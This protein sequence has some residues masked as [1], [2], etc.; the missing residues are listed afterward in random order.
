MGMGMVSPIATDIPT[1]PILI[2]AS[3]RPKLSQ[4]L[5]LM[6]NTLPPTVLDTPPLLLTPTTDMA[7]PPPMDMVSVTLDT[8]DLDTESV[9]PKLSQRLMLS[10]CPHTTLDT[11]LLLT[12]TMDI[13]TPPPMAMVTVTLDTPDLDMESVK[14]RLSQ[15]LMLN[16]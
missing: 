14:L 1:A 3:V 8:P 4:R 5:M 11:P 10:T 6:L 16:T 7:F 13:T 2:M 15:R 12:P 9:R